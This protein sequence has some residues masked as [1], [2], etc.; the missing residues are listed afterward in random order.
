MEDCISVSCCSGSLDFCRVL[1]ED[2]RLLENHVL[3]SGGASLP[4]EQVLLLLHPLRR[5]G[6]ANVL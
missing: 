5:D 3:S 4:K 6:H 2:L 1:R